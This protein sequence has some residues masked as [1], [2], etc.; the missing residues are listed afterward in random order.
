MVAT[1]LLLLTGL[2]GHIS[3]TLPAMIIISREIAISGLREW[4]ASL[5]K[6]DDVAVSNL[7]KYKTAAQMG[8]LLLLIVTPVDYQHPMLW[9]GMGLLYIATLLALWSM[10]EYLHAAW[11]EMKT[12]LVSTD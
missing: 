1:V 7:G 9:L 2:H 5:G 6:R 12:A 10:L 11:C 4:M 3:M 8:A